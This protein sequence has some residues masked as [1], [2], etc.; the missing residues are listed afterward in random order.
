ME[1]Y[2]N[3]PTTSMNHQF[4]LAATPTPVPDYAIVPIEIPTGWVMAGFL[5]LLLLIMVYKS[6]TRFVVNLFKKKKTE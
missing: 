4:Y 5:A 6:F 2:L 1:S 3:P